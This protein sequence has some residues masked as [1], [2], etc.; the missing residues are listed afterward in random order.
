MLSSRRKSS[1]RLCYA[2]LTE[3]FKISVFHKIESKGYRN[4]KYIY[5]LRDHDWEYV[6]NGNG[7]CF[8]NH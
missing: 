5:T 7:G 1:Y 2:K 6:S 8:E 4:N 3:D